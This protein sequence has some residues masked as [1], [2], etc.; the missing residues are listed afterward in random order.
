MNH[1]GR[2]KTKAT[3]VQEGC[4]RTDRPSSWDYLLLPITLIATQHKTWGI[5]VIHFVIEDILEGEEVV[6]VI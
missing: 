1:L 6:L 2:R 4:Q 5:L 3:N